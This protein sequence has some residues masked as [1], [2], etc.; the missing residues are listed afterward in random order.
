MTGRTGIRTL[1]VAAALSALTT[2]AWAQVEITFRFNDAEQ[3]ELRA[4]LDVFEQ[5]NPDIKVTMERVA[6]ADAREQFLREAAVGEGPDI[7]H[8]A[9]VWTRSMGDAGVFIPLNDLIEKYGIGAG[10]DDFISTDLASQDDGTIH[11]IPW[12]IDTFAM[13]YRK[14]ILEK[15]GITEFPTTWDGLREASAQ[16][17]EKT[18]ATGWAFPA[19][20]AATNSI[21]FFLNF[22]WWSHGWSLVDRAPDGKYVMGITPEQMAEGFAYYKSYFDQGLNPNAMLAVTNWG[23]QELIEGMVRGDIAIISTPEFVLNEMEAAWAARYP[24]QP[25]PFASTIHPK[26]LVDLRGRA[27]ARHQRQHR[28]PGGGLSG[29]AVSD[30]LADLR[31]LL[32]AVAGA[33][34]AGQAH[35]ARSGAHR[36]SGAAAQGAQLGPVLDRP[37]R[38]SHHVELGGSRCRC[39]V[40]RRED[41][42]RGLAGD[43]RQHRCGARRAIAPAIA[44]QPCRGARSA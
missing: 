18:G 27:A 30:Q 36:L 26:E 29:G 44:V 39:R 3:K 25:D 17:K 21:W 34:V 43:L 19:G 9:Q 42:A 14:D 16:I 12:T 20:S 35:R 2:S 22:Y 38:H 31:R 32:S 7:V 11:A 13:V 24:D 6:W 41:P 33:D 37:D 28:A 5:E 40:H 4:A 10:W 1:I 23:A 8:I 15:A